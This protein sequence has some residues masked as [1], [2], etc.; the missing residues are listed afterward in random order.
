MWRQAGWRSRNPELGVCVRF[1]ATVYQSTKY[2]L[3]NL[4][5]V[6][7]CQARTMNDSKR[8]IETQ[9]RFGSVGHCKMEIVKRVLLHMT[10][11]GQQRAALAYI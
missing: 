3:R 7:A 8:C 1:C 5:L 6:A 2:L 4:L 9:M 11:P 10:I